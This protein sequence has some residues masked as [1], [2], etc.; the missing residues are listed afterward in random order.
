M[1][2]MGLLRYQIIMQENGNYN[3]VRSKLVIEFHAQK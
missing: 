3:F 1:K 2:P